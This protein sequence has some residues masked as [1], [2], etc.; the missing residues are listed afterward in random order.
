MSNKCGINV[1]G[2]KCGINVSGNKCG[3]NVSNKS[4]SSN[5]RRPINTQALGVRSSMSPCVSRSET[6]RVAHT[7]MDYLMLHELKKM[8]HTKENHH[9]LKLLCPVEDGPYGIDESGC[10]YTIGID[11]TRLYFDADGLAIKW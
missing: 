6:C 3:I 9:L 1:S 5:N 8:E 10:V 4:G 11:G 2:N 7:N